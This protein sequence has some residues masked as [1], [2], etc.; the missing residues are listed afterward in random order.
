MGKEP[1]I[2]VVLLSLS[3][4][5]PFESGLERGSDPPSTGERPLFYG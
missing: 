4:W 1:S 2:P 5:T 3:L